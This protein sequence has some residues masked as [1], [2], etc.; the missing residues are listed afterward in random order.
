MKIRYF[1][2]LLL[3]VSFVGCNLQEVEY[4]KKQIYITHNGEQTQTYQIASEPTDTLISVYCGGSMAPESDIVVNLKVDQLAM[5]SLNQLKFTATKDYYQLLPD[6]CYS[7]P[8]YSTTIKKGTEYANLPI[9]YYTNKINPLIKYILPLSI[10][11]VSAY[12]VNP[13]L[14]T[15]LINVQLLNKYSGLYRFSGTAIEEGKTSKA[16]IL[17]EQTVVVAGKNA[18]LMQ[19]ESKTFELAGNSY[20]IRV[21]INSDNSITVTSD[22]QA[23]LKVENCLPYPGVISNPAIDNKYDPATGNMRLVYKYND[24]TKTGKMRIVVV[25]VTK[26]K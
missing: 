22:N 13:L 24:F 23:N 18:I 2:F 10:K 20:M 25:D 5:D 11:D 3:L 12:E 6:S 19:A 21:I 8:S 26:I 15:V 17:R 4:F 1:G 16:K 7:I 14:K 9:I